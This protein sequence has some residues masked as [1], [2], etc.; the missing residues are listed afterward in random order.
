MPDFAGVGSAWTDERDVVF[1]NHFVDQ[2]ML[3]GASRVLKILHERS[4]RSPDELA[5]LWN[6]LVISALLAASWWITTG[7]AGLPA[8]GALVMLSFPDVLKL[9]KAPQPSRQGQETGTVFSLAVA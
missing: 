9:L 1:I 8:A 4:Q 5:P 2:P 3:Q 6:L 7:P